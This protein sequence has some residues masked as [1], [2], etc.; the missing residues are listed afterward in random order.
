MYRTLTSAIADAPFAFGSTSNE[1]DRSTAF[2]RSKH[3]SVSTAAAG[4]PGESDPLGVETLAAPN[5][6]RVAPGEFIRRDW[7]PRVPDGI[8]ASHAALTPIRCNASSGD[9]LLYS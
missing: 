7:K 6:S 9:T 3:C 8:A 1:S 4:R 2:D 5:A